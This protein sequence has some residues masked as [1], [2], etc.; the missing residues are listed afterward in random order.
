MFDKLL[1]ELGFTEEHVT[2]YGGCGLLDSGPRQNFM[3]ARKIIRHQQFEIG[4]K[5]LI[6]HK[7]KILL[8]RRSDYG[9]WDMPGGRINQGES[10]AVA[11]RRELA[12]EL[13]ISAITT[14]NLI[15]AQ[16]QEVDHPLPN[17]CHLMLLF[18]YVQIDTPQNLTLSDE[19]IA[20][21]WASVN[22]LE[23]MRM[24]PATRQAAKNILRHNRCRPI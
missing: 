20:S 23:N 2:R 14:G 12:E 10:L 11:L 3:T 6:T 7:R 9:V 4:V 13:A 22:D 5:A 16:E 18:I 19:H 8:L 17:D 15:H 24:K 21:Y 1:S